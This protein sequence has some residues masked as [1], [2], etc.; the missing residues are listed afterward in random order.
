MND[1]IPCSKKLPDTNR[2]VLVDTG[3]DRMVAFYEDGVW[4]DYYNTD[5]FFNSIAN[6]IVYA[7]M[8]LPKPYKENKE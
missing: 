4:Y 8:E 5:M 2:D 3:V 6:S 7:W 1:W